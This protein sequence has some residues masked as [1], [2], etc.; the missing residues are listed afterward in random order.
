MSHKT[1]EIPDFQQRPETYLG[2][3]RADPEKDIWA[4]LLKKL[5]A[6]GLSPKSFLDVG[7]AAGDWLSF[8]GVNY[9]DAK[10]VG[11]DIDAKLIDTAKLRPV[12]AKAQLL[13]GDG[14][15]TVVGK[16]DVCTSFGTL[17]IFDS[18]EPLCQNLV[19][20]TRPGGR[21]YVQALLNPDDIDVRIAYG[22]NL[23]GLDWMRGF[24]IFSC[25]RVEAWAAM[26]G[27]KVN[28][29]QFHMTSFLPKRESLPHRAY[30]L[31]LA[32]GTRRTTNGL[33]LLLPET[34]MEIH[35]PN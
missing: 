2:E 8:C 30:T 14:L 3:N 21:I 26:R 17:G 10:L 16:F 25:A 20:N 24:N 13:C 9:P 6:D 19:A 5:T 29:S 1:F 33:C 7:C 31:D 34:L 28:F 32:D 12:L 22:D 35:V 18:F 11:I 4:F 27:L 23:N 15:N